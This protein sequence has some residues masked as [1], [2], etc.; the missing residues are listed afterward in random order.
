LIEG[1]FSLVL[2]IIGFFVKIVNL[3]FKIVVISTFDTDYK[4]KREIFRKQIFKSPVDGAIFG[5]K[6]LWKIFRSLKDDFIRIPTKYYQQFSIIGGLIGFFIAILNF[7]PW[8]LKTFITTYDLLY[9][10]GIGFISWGHY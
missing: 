3:L 1:L 5:G 10:I 2:F 4:A 8:A 9:V 7:I 6:Y